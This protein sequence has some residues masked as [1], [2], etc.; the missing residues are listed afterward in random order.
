MTKNITHLTSIQAR[1][2]LFKNESY[3]SIE[4]PSYFKFANL[5]R[6]LSKLRL[7]R[8]NISLEWNQRPANFEEVNYDLSTNKDGKYA[9][10]PMQIIHPLLYVDLVHSITEGGNWEYLQKRFE[11]FKNSSVEC[12][13]LPVVSNTKN[14]DKESQILEWWEEIEQ[15]SLSSAL[16]Y[17]YLFITD[18]TD[19][20]GAIYTHSISWAI[21]GKAF[22]KKN[23]GKKFL[24]N[25]LD[26]K[27][28]AMRHGQTNGIPQGSVL[29]DFVA[30]MVLG[31]ADLILTEK[32]SD[33]AKEDYRILRYRDDYRIF[34][35]KPD[36]GERILKELSA[37]LMSLG[38][39]L[40]PEKTLKSDDVIGKSLKSDKYNWP[41]YLL[42]RRSLQRELLV[43]HNASKKF[44]NSGSVTKELQSLVKHLNLNPEKLKHENAQV[45]ISILVDLIITNPKVTAIGMAAI[46]HI[47]AS[48]DNI[49]LKI[50][51]VEKIKA[52]FKKIP[53]TAL[54]EIWI[55]RICLSSE[56]VDIVPS[57]K[58]TQAVHTPH[59]F[60]NMWNSKWLKS[61]SPFRKILENT[62]F[63]DFEE[64]EKLNEIVDN[65]EVLMFLKRTKYN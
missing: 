2:F 46:S 32:I 64:I 1:Q 39:R 56:G 18:I 31:Y 26:S 50:E 54:V 20:Y 23:R 37:V 59:D 52:K 40:S 51:I 60:F 30:E 29:M 28:Q 47:L 9:W 48:I 36:I 62:L 38:M 34:T 13:S 33:L 58:I 5:L 8:T 3:C 17:D 41:N 45:L 22:A 16:D 61:N 42:K 7:K 63:V 14:S 11:E 24:G 25:K 12:K 43:I 49:F 57:E 55:Q 21:H 65:N 10:R 53:N 19:C 6:Q 44:P 4:L 15:E 35:N 27:I